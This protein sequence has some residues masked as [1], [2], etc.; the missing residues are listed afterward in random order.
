MRDKKCEDYLRVSIGT[1]D[2]L[3]RKQALELFQDFTLG[4]LPRTLQYANN[5]VYW[6]KEETV[7]RRLIDRLTEIGTSY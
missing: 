3:P 1:A 7:L 5:I 4:Q 2:T 6:L